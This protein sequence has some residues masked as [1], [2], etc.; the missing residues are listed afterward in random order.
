MD[1]RFKPVA[2]SNRKRPES[3]LPTEQ[4]QRMAR[5]RKAIAIKDAHR[6][7]ELA[8]TGQIQKFMAKLMSQ[9]AENG[10][11]NSETN[12]VKANQ[13][14]MVSDRDVMRMDSAAE[15]E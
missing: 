10:D 2:L 12:A 5:A 8:K 3:A 14:E 1:D 6:R 13:L 4:A 15:K 9:K 7:V 11:A